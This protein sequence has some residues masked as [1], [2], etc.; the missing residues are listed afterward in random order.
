[1]SAPELPLQVLELAGRTLPA[2]LPDFTFTPTH[3]QVFMFSA[4]TW[5][6]HHIHYSDEAARAE[7]HGGVVVQ[8]GLI[9]NFL[10]RMLTRWLGGRGEIRSL[11]WKVVRSA[12]PGE[13]LCCRGDLTSTVERGDARLFVCALRVLDPKNQLLADGAAELELG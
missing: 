8:R 2:C 9:G 4:V 5:N 6:R 13:A 3:A 11:S 7:G 10:A 12:R 1:M